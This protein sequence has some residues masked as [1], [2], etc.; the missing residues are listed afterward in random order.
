MLLQIH[1]TIGWEHGLHLLCHNRITLVPFFY[2]FFL[3]MLFR[4][5]DIQH[6]V[7]VVDTRVHVK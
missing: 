3:P 7:G 6:E 5:I 4:V 2:R 1:T